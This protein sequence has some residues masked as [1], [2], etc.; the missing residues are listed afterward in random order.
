MQTPQKPARELTD[1]LAEWPA[2]D[3]LDLASGAGRH[4]IWLRERGWRVTS[5]DREQ[6]DL[7][8]HEYRIEPARW[9]LIVC[10]LY[11]QEDLLPAIAAGIRERGAVA[12][13]GKTSGRFVTSLANYRRAFSGWKEISSGE[14]ERLAYFIASRSIAA[15]P[16]SNTS[17]AVSR[18]MTR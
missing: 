15:Q 1:A 9:D 10:W 3:A 7:E 17:G 6:A 5:I 16:A 2:G 8:K 11:W 4:S 13:A 18:L 14:D 12:L